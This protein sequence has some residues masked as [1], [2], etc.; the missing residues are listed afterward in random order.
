MVFV[1]G[2]MHGE[3]GRFED[4]KLRK[5][6]E[7]DCL[8]VCGD[9][10]FIWDD[11][12]REKLNLKKIC[13]KKYK[14]LFVEGTHENYELL[15]SY[16]VVEIFG[17]KA[18]SIG[19]NLY[20]LMR[21]EIYSIDGKTF[22]AFGGGDSTDKELRRGNGTW[23][24]EEMPSRIEMQYAIEKLEEVGRKVDYIITHE[25]PL[26][27]MAHITGKCRVD[28]LAGFFDEIA[29]HVNYK[30]WY[31]GSLHINKK[32]HHSNAQC[33]FTDIVKISE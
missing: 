22:F 33:L 15:S 8:I 5:L 2:D 1:T 24:K 26:T 12:K 25:P 14:T 19:G 3:Y 4:K 21:G 6:G 10:G 17:G 27:D 20:Q 30:K 13:E 31:F 18:R 23:W 11:S 7:D 16:Q 9:F 32:I 28:P 29:H